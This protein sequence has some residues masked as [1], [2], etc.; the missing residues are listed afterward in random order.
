MGVIVDFEERIPPG[1]VIVDRCA[2]DERLVI[3]KLPDE[4]TGLLWESWSSKAPHG[5]VLLRDSFNPIRSGFACAPGPTWRIWRVYYAARR[6]AFRAFYPIAWRLVLVLARLARVEVPPG[7][8][9]RGCLEKMGA[10]VETE[11]RAG[12]IAE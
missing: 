12:R 1:Y 6:L 10:A 7:V 3:A 5:W 4:R 11:R 8:T 9:I 2:W